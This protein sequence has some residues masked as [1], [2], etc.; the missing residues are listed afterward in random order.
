MNCITLIGYQL[1]QTKKTRSLNVNHF[2]HLKK[3]RIVI[4]FQKS[5]GK[6]IARPVI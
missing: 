1:A 2:Q 4:L 6:E 3:L 5:G